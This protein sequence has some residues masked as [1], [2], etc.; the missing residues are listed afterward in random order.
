MF[1]QRNRPWPFHERARIIDERC[2]RYEEEWQAAHAP[3]IEDFLTELDAETGAATWLELVMLDQELRRGRGE[4]PSLDDYRASCPD[5]KVWLDVSTGDLPP[6]DGPGVDVADLTVAGRLDEVFPGRPRPDRTS[7][8]DDPDVDPEATTAGEP[9]A[10][11][12]PIPQ[13]STAV[14]FPEGE[15]PRRGGLAYVR[16][17][18]CFGDYELIERL[19][20]G[21]MG[22]VFTARQKRLNRIVALKMIKTGFLAEERDIRLFRTEY[23]AVAALDHPHIV[24][25]LDSGEHRGILYYSMKLIAGKDLGD[26]QPSYRDRPA[27]IARLVARI[28]EAIAHAHERGILHR[29][30][31][32]SNI[33]VDERGEPHVIDFGLAKRLGFAG[34]SVTAVPTGGTPSY[35]APEQARGERDA[36]TTATDVYGLGAL[37]YSLLT[38]RAP[39]SGP[40]PED[41]VRQV[42]DDEPPRPRVRN[43]RVDPDLETICLKC[44]SREPAA[45]YPS[46]HGLAEDLQRWLDGRPILARPAS[47]AERLVKWVRRRKL[48]AALSAAAAIGAIVGVAGLGWG[49]SMAAL[50]RD[51]A[52]DGEQMAAVA[53]DRALEG[54]D[55]ARH[56]AYAASLNLA[57]RDWRDANVAEARR[58]LDET[59][60]PQG[61]SDLR[62]FEWYY[63][64]RLTRSQGLP[65]TG[66][67]FPVRGV[68]YSRDGSRIAS[69]SDDKTVK[70]WDA[71]TGRLIRSMTA[72]DAVAA[73]AFHP[74]GTRLASA[75]HDFAVTIW[76]V[77]TGQVIRRLPGHTRWIREVVYSPDGKSLASSSSDGTIRLWNGGDGSPIRTIRDHKEGSAAK[78]A[79]S[80]D[81]KVLAS[82]GGG[83]PTIRIRNVAT[84]ELIHTFRDDVPA[85]VEGL[86]GQRRSYP[87]YLKPVAFTSDGKMLATGGEDGTIRLCEPESGRLIRILRDPHHLEA[88][89]G[90]AFS[91]RGTRL[92]SISYSDRS[93]SVWD[94]AT[95]YLMRTIKVNTAEV[96]DIAFAPDS[97]HLAAACYDGIVRILDATQDQEARSLLESQE[98]VDVTFGPDGSFLATALANGTVTFRDLATGQ[99]V[100]TLPGQPGWTGNVVIS[101][102]GRRAA[103]GGAE[104]TVRVWDV[105]TGRM[106]HALPGHTGPIYSMAFARDGKVLASASHDQTVKLWDVDAGREIHT[107][108]GHAFEV[109]AVAFGPDGKTVISGDTDGFVMLWDA[110]SGRRLRAT[111]PHPGGIM[112]LAVSPDGRRLATGGS[113]GTIRIHDVATGDE[114]RAL[115]GHAGNL[116]GL[117][118]SP[119]GRRLVSSGE[120]RTVRIWDPESGLGVLVLRGHSGPVW[121]VAFSPD[122]TR[123][124]SA[125]AD[126]TVR[127]WEAD[128]APAPLGNRPGAGPGALQER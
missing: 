99:I 121:S 11:A 77:A 92:A 40:T 62:G 64:D 44:M 42:K 39:F 2:D 32:P 25:V 34:E 48:I 24:P 68:A 74:D 35:M 84:G 81:S 9:G 73:V 33:L 4:T 22:V 96:H 59:R 93:V 56:L 37:L 98:A 45:R 127:I 70:L 3:R 75:G 13:F 58:H 87:D 54:E 50:A 71:A 69:A 38:G 118:F 7:G 112:A 111:R 51:R 8:R 19:G 6:A 57:E 86:A 123:I 79:F 113:A 103:S 46:A 26:R 27:V 104:G 94:V 49:W 67:E 30:L 125:S 76:D 124:A 83:E 85:P 91:A 29:D 100:R 55:I 36:I 82:A 117:F 109:F 119:D 66:H 5:R 107:L 108:K 80:P 116:R 110:A 115:A 89:I 102:D 47:R 31:K 43:P 114:V 20:A 90:L 14:S 10:A 63:L 1:N 15:D 120:D 28:A 126:Q 88:V 105:A 101:P 122:G 52:I 16:P 106:I 128:P 61:K 97:V 21:G 17:G 23:E 78:L 53:R 18:A 41:V 65:L 72:R 60:P 12:D 95:G